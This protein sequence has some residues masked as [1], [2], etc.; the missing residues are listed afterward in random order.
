[1]RLFEPVT[2]ASPAP[3]ESGAERDC[4]PRAGSR[5]P[6]KVKG[7]RRD[8]QTRVTAWSVQDDPPRGLESLVRSAKKRRREVVHS[9]ELR[10]AP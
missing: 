10:P 8:A 1:M 6:E 4:E 3:A 5:Y 2:R 9:L 7:V